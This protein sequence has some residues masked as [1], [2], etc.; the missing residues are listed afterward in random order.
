MTQ[1]DR[2]TRALVDWLEDQ[3][4]SAPEQLLDSLLADVTLTQ[5]RGRWKAVLRR[6]PMIQQNATR[7]ALALGGVALAATIGFAIWDG[8]SMGPIAQSPSPS[9][10]PS[11][12]GPAPA[13]P[14]QPGGIAYVTQGPQRGIVL[15]DPST[16]ASRPLTPPLIEMLERNGCARQTDLDVQQSAFVDHQMTW[17]PD[18][19]AL[20]FQL[21]VEVD[22]SLPRPCGL[23]VVS[24]DGQT[25]ERVL[26]APDWETPLDY[27]PAWAPDGSQIAVALGQS[28]ALVPLD[29]SNLVDLGRPCDG[30]QPAVFNSIEG[31][32]PDGSLIAAEFVDDGCCAE[33]TTYYIAVVDVA[34]AEW[35]LLWSGTRPEAPGRQTDYWLIGWLH[36]G[37]VAGLSN[38]GVFAAE[39]DEPGEWT[40]LPFPGSFV[41]PD[42]H[43]QLGMWSPDQTRVALYDSRDGVRVRHL[44]TGRIDTIADWINAYSIAWSP[45]GEQLA[46]LL[47]WYRDL[48]LI[49]ADGGNPRRLAGSGGEPRFSSVA[50]QPVWPGQE[51]ER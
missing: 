49:E 3:P 2:F 29:G 45:D 7:Y 43:R 44:A 1:H 38:E 9:P 27:S 26:P 15:V 23:F 19:R 16:R 5:Q 13:G 37:R 4:S 31:W 32:S 40:Q 8:Q 50:W 47:G 20:A 51:N 21:A 42:G 24:S 6:T 39:P 35:T 48:W 36:D 33:D 28:I 41:D 34:T 18:G 10:T 46:V 14:P 25:L 12:A 22:M 17:S 11:L 30:C